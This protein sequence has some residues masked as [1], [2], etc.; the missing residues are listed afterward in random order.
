MVKGK[1]MCMEDIQL[2]RK[3]MT[4]TSV[5][6]PTGAR[7]QLLVQNVKRTAIRFV[8]NLP[9]QVGAASDFAELASGNAVDSVNAAGGGG[10]V[11]INPFVPSVALSIDR[12]GLVVTDSWFLMNFSV[13]PTTITIVETFLED[14]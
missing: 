3:A 11:L 13:L 7:Q 12:D 10:E 4:A 1:T 14:E 2:G 9:L 5:I 6:N 8:V